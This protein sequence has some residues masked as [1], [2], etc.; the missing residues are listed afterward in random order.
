MILKSF[1]S[2]FVAVI[3]FWAIPSGSIQGLL[4]ILGVLSRPYTML[5]IE[6]GSMQMP[7]LVY[8]HFDL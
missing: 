7:Y 5:G 6:L 8:Y 2:F 4:R 3:C 1:F